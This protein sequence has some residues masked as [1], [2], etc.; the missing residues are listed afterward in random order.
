MRFTQAFI[1]TLK[2]VPKEATTP[3][4]VLLLRGGFV[5][6]VG[7]GIYE[8]LPL[9]LRV[10]AKVA[11]I[12]RDEMDRTGAQE[13]LMPALLPRE[14]FEESGRWDSFGDTLLR[15]RDRKGADYHLG[16]T[17]EEIITDMVR[18]DVKSYRQLPLNLY[19]IQMKFRDE[20]RP[21]AGLLRCREF[22]MKDA[23]S[24]DV[25]EEQALASYEKMRAAYHRVFQRLGLEYRIV[26]ADSGAMG[27]ST[28]AEFQVLAQNG[29]DA[30]VACTSCDYAANVEVAASV[31]PLRE[32]APAAA[33]AKVATPHKKTIE[34]VAAFLGV[35]SSATAKTLMYVADGELV[36]VLVRGD[37]EGNDV[38]VARATGARE[39][40]MATDAEIAATSMPVGFLGPIGWKGRVIADL[41]LDT[42]GGF[43]SGANEVDQHF[44]SVVLG[45][46]Y[47]A[48][49]ADVRTIGKGDPCAKCGGTLE[50]YRGI[51]GGHI[52]I[53]GT[54]YSAKMKAHFLDDDNAEKPIVMG[55]YGIGVSRLVATAI[56]QHNDADGILWPMSI[57]PYHVV[58]TPAGKGED[59]DRAANEVYEALLA[60]GVE[61]L[62]D[63]RDERPGVKFKDA[64][65]IGIPLRV[66][67]GKKGLAEGKGELKARHEKDAV[68]I[69]L[70]ELAERVAQLVLESG[71]RL[72]TS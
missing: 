6:M 35:P 28:S 46:D 18:R 4:H 24:F 16:P 17:H 14:Y 27:G 58:I 39:V 41:A 43:V 61:T 15:M 31:A 66:T 21:R 25:S 55:C 44:T 54:H 69:P 7:A 26:A 64:D 62:L 71:G 20:A 36:M 22:L 63:D 51:E 1:P 47:Q 48:T 60:R 53:L 65:L 33:Y 11:S 70:G 37:H 67:I 23:Y 40:R 30:I 8:M 34:D 56:E 32:S 59:L 13:V 45:R 52:F 72:R 57:A 10:L 9:G 49:V 50:S 42:G 3:S 29:E 38:K 12:V 5:R 19:Q 2:E 68:M